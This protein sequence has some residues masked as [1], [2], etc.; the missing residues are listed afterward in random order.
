MSS[1]TKDLYV[2]QGS[3]FI[4]YIDLVSEEGVEFNVGTYTF[5]SQ[6]RQSPRSKTAINLIVTQDPD[7]ISRIALVITPAISNLFTSPSYSYDIEME[8][9]V[10]NIAR[11]R[12]GQIIVDFNTTR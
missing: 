11:I 4:E 6:A 12:Q 9:M 7:S 1:K 2:E 8:D 5:R 3:T 10:G